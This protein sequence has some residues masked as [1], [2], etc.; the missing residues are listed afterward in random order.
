LLAIFPSD[1]QIIIIR[2]GGG[3]GEVWRRWMTMWGGREGR[4][5]RR[6][7][8]PQTHETGRLDWTDLME[9]NLVL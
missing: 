9:E 8:D 3:E 6:S 7:G 5:G 4:T 1:A 2:G